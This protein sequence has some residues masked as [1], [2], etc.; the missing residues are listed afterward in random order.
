LNFGLRPGPIDLCSAN[1]DDFASGERISQKLRP[2]LAWRLSMKSFRT[3]GQS[4][5]RISSDTLCNLLQDK[6]DFDKVVLVDCRGDLEFNGG[7]ISVA[8]HA[9]TEEDFEEVFHKFYTE[10][11]CFVF[12]CEFSKVRAPLRLKQFLQI[13]RSQGI[14][15]MPHCYVLD[16]GYSVFYVLHSEQCVDGYRRELDD[17]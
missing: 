16:R 3:P 2:F 14:E 7:H 1:P 12:H 8:I 11:T 15:S 5:D 4:Y 6:G 9:Q 10:N 13:G 17:D